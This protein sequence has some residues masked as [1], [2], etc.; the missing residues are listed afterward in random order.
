MSQNKERLINGFSAFSEKELEDF[1]SKFGFCLSKGELI[2]LQKYSKDISKDLTFGEI[3]LFEKICKNKNNVIFS[4]IDKVDIDTPN[5]H[6]CL[7]FCSRY[8][9]CRHIL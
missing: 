4:E 1:A 6:I 3:K 7:L 2:Y 8:S 5:P 9:I